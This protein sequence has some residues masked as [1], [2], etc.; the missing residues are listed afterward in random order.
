[1]RW[2]RFQKIV[3]W[4]N[5]SS[6]RSNNCSIRPSKDGFC[7]EKDSEMNRAVMNTMTKRAAYRNQTST[8]AFTI[9]TLNFHGSTIQSSSPIK[10]IPRPRYLPYSQL[11]LQIYA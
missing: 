6:A 4:T 5:L 9:S 8:T 10:N 2:E 3:G 11:H 7:L 1:M